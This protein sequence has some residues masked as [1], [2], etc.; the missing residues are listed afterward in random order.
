MDWL[1]KANCCEALLRSINRVLSPW[2]ATVDMKVARWNSS[3]CCSTPSVDVETQKNGTCDVISAQLVFFGLIAHILANKC[4]GIW[5]HIFTWK[6]VN[7]NFGKSKVP[8][9]RKDWSWNTSCNTN[10]S[11]PK[12][13]G[14]I[15]NCPF[16]KCIL[17]LE[18]IYRST[19][20]KK[21]PP[22]PRSL[23]PAWCL[24]ALGLASVDLW[25]HDVK[26]RWN[27]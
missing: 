5:V 23:H 9:A 17:S 25:V 20:P 6:K 3:V 22:N 11:P 26:A 7:P 4:Q 14:K 10:M 1:A 19:F 8:F 13:V 18:G 27:V 16:P 12:V 15:Y 2:P 24:L 21:P